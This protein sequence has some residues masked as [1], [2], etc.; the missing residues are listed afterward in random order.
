MIEDKEEL[1]DKKVEVVEDKEEVEEEV[2]EEDE[3][4]DEEEKEDE[5]RRKVCR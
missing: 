2:E 4:E 3:E 1:E 5:P